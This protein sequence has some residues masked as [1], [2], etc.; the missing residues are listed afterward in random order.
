MK[1]LISIWM[2]KHYYTATSAPFFWCRYF[3]PFFKFL[4]KRISS[5]THNTHLLTHSFTPWTPSSINSQPRC[6]LLFLETENYCHVLNNPSLNIFSRTSTY[7]KGSLPFTYY[8]HHVVGIFHLSHTFISYVILYIYIYTHTHTLTLTL[9]LSLSHSHSRLV[10]QA[11][12]SW[13]KVFDASTFWLLN[14]LLNVRLLHCL[15]SLGTNNPGTQ[16][17]IA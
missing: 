13:Y 12:N 2:Y 4:Y 6:F 8:N 9:S 11:S 14:W 15:K 16:Y 10:N 7:S 3:F 17:H 5:A 1:S